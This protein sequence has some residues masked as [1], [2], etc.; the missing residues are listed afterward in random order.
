MTRSKFRPPNARSNG[1]ASTATKRAIS[2]RGTRL[3]SACA[4][5]HAQYRSANPRRSSALRTDPVPHPISATSLTCGGARSTTLDAFP[6]APRSSHS[7]SSS[8]VHIA[9]FRAIRALTYRR[10]DLLDPSAARHPSSEDK[11]CYPLASRECLVPSSASCIDFTNHSATR[12]TS[13]MSDW[14]QLVL[15]S[16]CCGRDQGT[17]VGRDITATQQRVA[18]P[19]WLTFA[20]HGARVR[21]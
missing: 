20:R 2:E 7:P 16:R 5:S 3:Q 8:A 11:R 21:G 9:V 15:A 17:L 14:S 19:I 13:Y 10:R 12:P 4:G 6:S 1:T 18:T